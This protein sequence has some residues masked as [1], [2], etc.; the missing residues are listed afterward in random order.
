[1]AVVAFTILIGLGGI[2]NREVGRDFPGRHD[3]RRSAGM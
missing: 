1:M 3:E 2:H